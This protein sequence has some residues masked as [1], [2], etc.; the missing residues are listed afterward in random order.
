MGDSPAENSS[1]IRPRLL[2]QVRD[3][4]RRLHY[5]RRTEESY[6]TRSSALSTFTASATPAN[7]ANRR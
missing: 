5:S 2:D 1:P 7:W 6:T 4:I 3:A